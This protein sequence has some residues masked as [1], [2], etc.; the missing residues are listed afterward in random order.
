MYSNT[1]TGLNRPLGFQEVEAPRFRDN[2]H[3]IVV[4]LSTPTPAV[5]TPH[6]IFLILIAVRG[7]LSRTQGHSAF[8]IKNS[9]DTI[10]KQNRDHSVCGVMPQ[11][12]AP[13]H[14]SMANGNIYGALGELY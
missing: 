6:E 8:G 2:R 12:I 3:M 4:R 11:S 10:G 9:N 5:F 1:C 13:P 7:C 14:A